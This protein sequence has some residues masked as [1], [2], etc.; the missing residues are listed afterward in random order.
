MPLERLIEDRMRHLG[1]NKSS[2]AAR[3]GLSRPTL[4]Q[5]MNG[6]GTISSL[7]QVLP[8]LACTWAWCPPGSTHPGGALAE[9]RRR[10]R[11]TQAQVSDRL[12]LSRPVIIGIEKR[13][14]GELASLLGYTKHLGMPAPIAPISSKRG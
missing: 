6:K 11:L 9:L 8:P 10:R 13:M 12:S 14:R 5:I 1:F 3:A 2:L 4:Q 7:A